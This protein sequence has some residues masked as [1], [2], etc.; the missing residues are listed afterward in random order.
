LRGEWQSGGSKFEIKLFTI[1]VS[2]RHA[3]SPGELREKA[4]DYT[5]GLTG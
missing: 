5:D 3:V 2:G 1:K 4:I